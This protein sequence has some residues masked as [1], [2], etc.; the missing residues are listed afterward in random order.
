MLLKNCFTITLFVACSAA[1]A[2]GCGG[3]RRLPL[4]GND[5]GTAGI[6]GSS[7]GVDAAAGRGGTGGSLSSG[8]G[9]TG[10]STNPF[11]AG[12]GD[13]QPF[14]G[15]AEMQLIGKGQKDLDVA[16]FHDSLSR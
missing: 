5:G 13:T 4:Q 8:T 16:K 6:G 9:G 15:P 7:A 2:G 10:G 1:L 14:G 3:L 12:G 11:D